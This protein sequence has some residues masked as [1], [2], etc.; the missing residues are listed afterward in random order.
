MCARAPISLVISSSFFLFFVFCLNTICQNNNSLAFTIFHR[1]NSLNDVTFPF[2]ISLGKKI[3]I[4]RE[5]RIDRMYREIRADINDCA[6]LHLST[7][8]VV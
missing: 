5:L 4:Q 6:F 2:H 1:S 8:L 3:Q 7:Y